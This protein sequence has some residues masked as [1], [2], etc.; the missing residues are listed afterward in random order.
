LAKP[1]LSC[2]GQTLFEVGAVGCGHAM[3]ALNNFVA[4]TQLAALGEAITV[5]RHFGLDPEVMVSVINAST[6]RSWSSENLMIQHILSG[7]YGSGF[8]VGLLAKDVNIAAELGRQIGMDP[9]LGSFVRDL[10]AEARD[11]I[12][13][14]KDHTHAFAYWEKRLQRAT[15]DRRGQQDHR[16]TE[17][18][19]KC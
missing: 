17:R 1:V 15:A 10:W 6:G 13:A 14:D 12:G 19:G 5:G 3:K 8:A 4:G 11:A 2:M 18:A 16:R 7:A 9:R